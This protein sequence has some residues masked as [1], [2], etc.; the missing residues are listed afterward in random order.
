MYPVPLVTLASSPN[1]IDL[2][3]ATGEQ[4]GDCFVLNV[5]QQPKPYNF[6]LSST[7]FYRNESLQLNDALGTIKT[8]ERFGTEIVTIQ[9]PRYSQNDASKATGE[10]I[11]QYSYRRENSE[12]ANEVLRT[13]LDN[14]EVN[15]TY[16]LISP[17]SCCKQE[18]PTVLVRNAGKLR[19]FQKNVLTEIPIALEDSVGG[20][21][22]SSDG[23]K[24]AFLHWNYE[25]DRVGLFSSAKTGVAV[26]E[27]ISP[28]KITRLIAPGINAHTYLSWSPD[29]RYL[30]YVL[31][32]GQG[33][34][35]LD[36]QK[37]QEVFRFL[38]EDSK[39][40][41]EESGG[42]PLVWVDD[43]EF[44]F[45]YNGKLYLGTLTNPTSK[46]IADG[47]TNAESRFESTPALY[48]PLWSPDGK[49]VMYRTKES[50]IIQN[51]NTNKKY[52]LGKQV[53]SEFGFYLNISEIGWT[54]NNEFLFEEDNQFKL[55]RIE[56]S[57]LSIQNIAELSGNDISYSLIG[58]GP[59]VAVYSGYLT[60]P[61]TIYDINQ[62]IKVCQN[63]HM[64]KYYA[65]YVSK[66]NQNVYVVA[67][68]LVPEWVQWPNN[69][70]EA[71]DQAKK[72]LEVFNITSC[73]SLGGFIV[74]DST[75]GVN[76]NVQ[77]IPD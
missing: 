51:I 18:T 65:A 40:D 10:L 64:G 32:D 23:N 24:V 12:R 9:I 58:S 33:V 48:E 46:V 8:Y 73:E 25:R 17:P 74:D 52:Q 19:I 67:N 6:N 22:I 60:S 20:E 36:T 72:V 27:A 34:G 43:K 16:A 69:S 44:S 41:P 70:Y 31:D 61:L 57:G 2:S 42:R 62:K 37:Q 45:I 75:S 11:I 13:L 29:G 4:F 7:N 63:L 55:A 14:L 47:A 77:M 30:S 50:A 15:Q 35:M 68:P 66:T 53:E 26:V 54:K 21:K 38:A 56:L 76:P 71:T 28:H 5:W 59:Y 49:Y 3:W 1:C 39:Y